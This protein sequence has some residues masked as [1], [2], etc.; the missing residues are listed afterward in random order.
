MNSLQLTKILLFVTS[1]SQRRNFLGCFPIDKIPEYIP[2]SSFLVLNTDRSSQPGE[3]WLLVDIDAHNNVCFFDTLAQAPRFYSHKLEQKLKSIDA[4]FWQSN[5]VVQHLMS[6]ACGFHVVYFA[7]LRLR[8]IS[9]SQ[10]VLGIYTENLHQNDVVARRFV[11]KQ[12]SI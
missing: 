6:V 3:H 10:I 7:C 2:H 1:K 12:F 9:C 5:R 4:N 11:Q 8:G